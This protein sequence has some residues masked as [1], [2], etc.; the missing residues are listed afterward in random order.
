MPRLRLAVATS[1]LSSSLRSAIDLASQTGA[2][3]LQFDA[4]HQLKPADLSETGRRQLL[5]TLSERNLQ[6]AALSFPLRRPL[7]DEE[8]LDARL[9]A[10]QQA[11]QFAWDLKA[12][13]LSCRIGRIVDE[14]DSREGIRQ[15]EVLSDLA[16]HSNRIG[17]TFSITPAGDSPEVLRSLLDSIDEGPLGIDFDPAERVMSRQNPVGSLRDLHHAVT[18]LTLRDAIRDADGGG[19]ETVLGR[20][21][22]PWDELIATLDEMNYT[23]WL[24]LDR[25]EGDDPAGDLQ[26]AVSFVTQVAAVQ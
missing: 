6:V 24:T 19:R 7:H 10:I 13:V 16:R 22:V 5:H 9:A 23:G 4:R 25:R 14:V 3:G 15:R 2:A 8:Q 17:V 18:H 1:R 12:R 21:E 26:R 11:M 20:G